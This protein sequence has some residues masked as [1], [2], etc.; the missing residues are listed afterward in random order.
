M[1]L[2][3]FNIS[4]SRRRR[5]RLRSETSPLSRTQSVEPPTLHAGHQ[6]TPAASRSNRRGSRWRRPAAAPPP[7]GPRG[8]SGIVVCERGR[9]RSLNYI[10]H[11]YRHDA[12]WCEGSHGRLRSSGCQ[13]GRA[14]AGLEAPRPRRVW[15]RTAGPALSAYAPQAGASSSEEHASTAAGSRTSFRLQLSPPPTR[16]P[17]RRSG[18]QASLAHPS[19][20]S[21]G[22]RPP[23]QAWATRS[24][25][26]SRGSSG[27]LC[28]CPRRPASRPPWTATSRSP[29]PPARRS[30][31]TSP[32]P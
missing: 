18:A 19:H 20:A 1:L 4:S 9:A 14:P 30:V 16:S 32:C 13:A 15:K 8:L 2:F 17:G 12:H 28:C 29:F 31:S 10:S 11:S 27:P 6:R 25:C 3:L 22:P 24:G 5:T 7:R 21:S 23:R 26:P